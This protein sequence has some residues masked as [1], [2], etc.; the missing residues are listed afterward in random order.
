M[1]QNALWQASLGLLVKVVIC[2]AVVGSCSLISTRT[3][4]AAFVG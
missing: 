4:F 3:L 1:F 2:N